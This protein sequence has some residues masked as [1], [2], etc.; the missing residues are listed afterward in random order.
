LFDISYAIQQEIEKAGYGIVQEFAGHG[1]GKNMHEEPDVPNYGTPGQGM[2][3]REGMTFALEPMLTVG[4]SALYIDT[5][6][7]TAKTQD[8][9]L[10]M[11]V[12]DTVLVTSGKTRNINKIVRKVFYEKR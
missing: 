8:G 11:H 4:D 1:I 3:L 7:W 12:E 6:K 10:T 9:S 5:D 2:I